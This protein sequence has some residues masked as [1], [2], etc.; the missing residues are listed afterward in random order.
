M[1]SLASCNEGHD[2][3]DGS[4]EVPFSTDW[5]LDGSAVAGADLQEYVHLRRMWQ[6]YKSSKPRSGDTSWIPGGYENTLARLEQEI[7]AYVRCEAWSY[8]VPW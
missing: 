2:S 1:R 4:P 6:Q 8:L 5:P 7:N 3:D